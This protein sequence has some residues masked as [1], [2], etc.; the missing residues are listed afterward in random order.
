MGFLAGTLALL[1]TLTITITRATRRR[2]ALP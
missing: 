1:V 2:R